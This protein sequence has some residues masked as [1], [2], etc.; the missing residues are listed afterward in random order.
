MVGANQG[1]S[2]SAGTK[3][4]PISQQ[5]S[6]TSLCA[7]RKAIP[8]AFS[9]F[10]P[11][12]SVVSNSLRPHSLQPTSFCPWDFPGKNSEVDCYFLLQR[13]LSTQGSNQHLLHWQADSLPPGEALSTFLEPHRLGRV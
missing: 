10:L 8:E 5:I 1:L 4:I 7:L 11:V 3:R 2:L 6:L 9:T 12:C 13:I